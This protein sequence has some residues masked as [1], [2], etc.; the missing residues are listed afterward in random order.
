MAA[1]AYGQVD[2]ATFRA[3]VEGAL[4]TGVT[5]FD[6]SASWGEGLGERI[7]GETHRALMSVRNHYAVETDALSDDPI[8]LKRLRRVVVNSRG[9]VERLQVDYVDPVAQS[10]RSITVDMNGWQMGPLVEA[11]LVKT[12]EYQRVDSSARLALP[13]V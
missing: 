2:E 11:G 5:T 8:D 13:L 4:E 7:V 10:P 3:T 6:C 12:G 1:Q 9:F